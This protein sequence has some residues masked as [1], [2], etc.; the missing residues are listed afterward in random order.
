MTITSL[1]ICP[2]CASVPALCACV[3][4]IDPNIPPTAA[5]LLAGVRSGSWLQAQEFP[6]LEWAVPAVIPEGLTIL[7]GPPKVG[8]SWLVL[9]LCLTVAAGGTALAH[10]PVGP[11]REVL[12]L[13]LE[14]G[15]RRM[16]YRCQ[17]LLE[18]EGIPA[19]FHY[20]TKCQPK[21]VIPT[22]EAWMEQHPNTGLVVLDTIGKVMPPAAAG[23]TQYER[24]YQVMGRLKEIS[25]DYPGLSF[26]VVNHTRKSMGADFLD[27]NSGTQGLAGAADATIVLSRDRLSDSAILSVTGRDVEES[28]LALATNGMGW[29]LDGH[30]VEE[31]RMAAIEIRAAAAADKAMSK[32]SDR[33][34]EVVA[35]VN[36]SHGVSPKDVAT[37][38]SM[39]SKQASVYL[40]RAFNSGLVDKSGRGHYLPITSVVSVAS[41]VTAD[42]YPLKDNVGSVVSVGMLY[43]DDPLPT[44]PTDTT[45][46]FGE[47]E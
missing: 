44:L 30:S 32:V 9:S 37:A 41:V 5:M 6:P 43:P 12:Y 47:S 14:D 26:V 10:I 42:S 29:R 35:L 8:K 7:A 40:G 13:A 25:D 46:S 28:E 45:E 39:D 34:K 1:D 33:M 18:G 16:Q 11:P 17:E 4:D 19:N 15:D 24:D 38:L 31:A 2:D 20:L 3:E 22:I 27:N 21:M 36:A 23:Q